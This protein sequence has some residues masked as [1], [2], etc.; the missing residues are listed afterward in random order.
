MLD[1]SF[2]DYLTVIREEFSKPTINEKQETLLMNLRGRVAMRKDD[3]ENGIELGKYIIAQ[4][5]VGNCGI[6]K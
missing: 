3:I 2:E 4:R 1:S 6:K 5:Q